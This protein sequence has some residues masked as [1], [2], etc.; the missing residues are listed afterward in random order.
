V[1]LSEGDIRDISTLHGEGVK[2]ELRRVPQEKPVDFDDIIR[3]GE[4]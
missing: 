2:I 1:L 4:S 3:C